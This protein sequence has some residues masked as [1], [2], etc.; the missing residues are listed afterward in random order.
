METS[1]Q[2]QKKI[3]RRNRNAPGRAK[4]RGGT[5][6]P[7]LRLCRLSDNPGAGSCQAA[8]LSISDACFDIPINSKNGK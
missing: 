3:D 2:N 1:I 8:S 4:G 6:P 5:H 7:S